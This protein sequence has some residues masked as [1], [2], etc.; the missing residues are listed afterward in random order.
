MLSLLRFLFEKK[1]FLFFL[2]LEG[3][4]G[5]MIFSFNKYQGAFYFNSSN[6]V[7]A[8]IF[9][10]NKGITSYFDLQ[11]QNDKL[12]VENSVLR[13]LL[14]LEKAV[15]KVD[16]L[17]LVD[18]VRRDAFDF[19][20][21][22]IVKNSLNSTQNYI[23]IDKGSLDGMTP[24]MGLIGPQGVV[25]EIKYCSDHYAT[26]FSLLHVKN[27]ISAKLSG[28]GAVGTLQWDGTDA[29]FAKLNYIGRHYFIQPGDSVNTSGF[30]AVFP[31]GIPIG[32]VEKVSDDN[33]SF[34]N[35]TVRLAAD[36]GSLDHVY[37]I[38]SKRKPEM[39]SLEIKLKK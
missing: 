33:Q 5:W 38:R 23:T 1:N 27:G 4:C 22:R 18:S 26:G 37:V 15:R 12:A 20:P 8:N 34:Y 3:L 9:S 28:S 36:F 30:N 13:K 11:K 10:L 21:A 25:G 6:A 17:T 29:R 2:V 19:I 14:E 39:D 16:A 7:V 35:I 31:A 24:Y 32:V